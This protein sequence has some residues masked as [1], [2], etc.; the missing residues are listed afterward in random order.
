MSSYPPPQLGT[1][2]ADDETLGALVVSTGGAG[3]V[4]GEDDAG[5]RLVLQMFGPTPADYA[6]VGGLWLR[7]LLAFRALALG[8][9]VLVHTEREQTWASFTRIAS[10]VRG[11][12]QCVRDLPPALSGRPNRPVLVLLDSLSSIGGTVP[13]AGAWSA[14]VSASDQATQWNIDALSRAD[15]VF[16]QSLSPASAMLLGKALG[17][18][19]PSHLIGLPPEQFSLVS[20]G[21]SRRIRAQLTDAERWITGAPNPDRAGS[22]NGESLDAPVF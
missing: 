1:R 17:L 2:L 16:A 5:Q 15:L 7:Q 3:A 9:Q 13:Q 21:T 10:G 4:L 14:V 12:L 19:D 11:D 8:A 18:P 6:I 22:G 20:R